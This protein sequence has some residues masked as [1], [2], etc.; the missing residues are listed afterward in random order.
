[1]AKD[2]KWGGTPQESNTPAARWG[3]MPQE[4]NTPGAH[5]GWGGTPQESD[6]SGQGSAPFIADVPEYNIYVIEGVTYR[7]RNL[8]SAQSGEA[9][10]FRIENGGRDFALKLYR[11]GVKPNHAVLEKVKGLSGNALL[12][13][14][15]A[16]GTWH[17][18]VTGFDLD[19]EI[20]QYLGGGSM[21]SLRLEGDE[22]RM[23]EMAVGMAAALDFA[24]KHGILHRDVKPANFLFTD[25]TRKH[26]VLTDWGLAKVLDDSGRTVTDSGRTKIYAAPE[27]YT[28]IPDKPTYVDAK[29]DFFSMGM[30]LL[31]L[32][33]GEG[34]LIADEQRLVHDKQEETLPYPAKGE[35]SEHLLSL[36]KALTR[37]NPEKRAGFDDIVRWAKGE[38]IYKEPVHDTIGEYRIVFSAADKLI[39][40]NNKELAGMMEQHAEL[41]KKYLYSDALTKKFREIERPEIAVELELI[42]EMRYPGNRD[43]GLYAAIL[44]LDAD[45]PYTGID[46]T[47]CRTQQEIAREV[48]DNR[49]EYARKLASP[50]HSLWVYLDASGLGKEI[51]GMAA[52]IKKDADGGILKL[53]YMLDPSLPYQ[54]DFGE[55]VYEIDTLVDYGNVA[56]ATEMSFPYGFQT[57]TGFLAWLATRDKALAGKAKSVVAEHGTGLFGAYCVHYAILPDRGYDL[58]PLADSALVDPQDMAMCLVGELDGTVHDIGF[59]VDRWLSSQADFLSSP[60]LAYLLS[61]DIYEPH[62][63]FIDYCLDFG[64]EDNCHKY[65]PYG[66]RIAKFKIVS[67]FCKNGVP[68]TINGVDLE[69]PKDIPGAGKLTAAQAD[70]VAD[71]VAVF[72]Q[73]NPRAD[74]DKTSYYRLT[75]D[76]YRFLANS[77]P[78]CGYCRRAA[79]KTGGYAGVAKAALNAWRRVKTVKWLMGLLCLVPMVLVL[80]LCSYAVVTE[81]AETLGTV[82][83]NVGWWVAVICGVIA[84]LCVWSDSN[85]VGGV[86]SYVIVAAV[87]KLVFSFL[88]PLAPWLVVLL[89][90][91][92]VLYF[93]VM[94]F[95]RTVEALPDVVCGFPTG[96]A[97]EREFVG[98]AFASRDKLLPGVPPNFPMQVIHNN[99]ESANRT[100]RRMLRNMLYMLLVTVLGVLFCAW[101]YADK[102]DK[103]LAEEGP[104][105]RKLVQGTFVGDV[106][107]TPSVM[108]IT[109]DTCCVSAD[110]TISYRSGAVRQ[111]MVGCPEEEKF[112]IV[113][114]KNKNDGVTLSIDTVFVSDSITVLQGSY[115]NSKGNTRTVNYRSNEL[116]KVQ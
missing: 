63:E 9:K 6:T 1:M 15:Y 48:F 112:P 16:H 101:M 37:R 21:A 74:F 76:Y 88:S 62:I 96:E 78:Q 93:I 34:N 47:E 90:L 92:V 97:F 43:A 42:T 85:L 58:V 20:M 12:V 25:S 102:P 17:D 77:L 81:G 70:L 100:F 61:K 104:V 18:D 89:L 98:A 64:S 7:V 107:R 75:A 69:S 111:R 110:M 19:Y 32:W 22:K 114:R 73:E 80:G 26:F 14:I 23:K 59:G 109:S 99:K 50:T 79:G 2:G 31:A 30:A 5:S 45:R 108:I 71:W 4:S 54:I 57:G 8:I 55:Q 66:P 103:P 67:G 44:L 24:H 82:F 91:V 11:P 86:I 65:G 51:K 87:I 106:A 56:L 68:L 105:V 10:I 60:L 94:I 95:R 36:I 113:L 115:V 41:A 116:H 3:G 83:Q 35:M 46:G 38:V 40:H 39:A 33:K 84:G 29:A 13:D 49:E 28:Y 52:A 72:Y 27:M 53:C